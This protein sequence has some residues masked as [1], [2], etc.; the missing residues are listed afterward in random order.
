MNKE[1]F[2]NPSAQDVPLDSSDMS[3]AT[4]V[5]QEAHMIRHL[6]RQIILED[7]EGFKAGTSEIDY[8]HKDPKQMP[9]EL[10]RIWSQEADHAF[11][12]SV[13]KVHWIAGASPSTYGVFERVD[14]FLKASGKDEI[15]T[16]GYIGNPTKSEWGEF[17]VIVKGRTTLAARSMNDIVSGYYR[18]MDPAEI[19]KYRKTSGIP[20]RAKSFSRGAAEN[21]ILSAN[22]FGNDQLGNELIVDNWKATGLIAPVWFLNTMK[23]SVL[24]FKKR[25][26]SVDFWKVMDLF[27]KTELP[28][29]TTSGKPF[30]M[31]P[32]KK[33]LETE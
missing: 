20:R 5:V 7:M 21:F 1:I 19:E 24:D 12:D 23:K 22:D 26:L 32:I 16:M 30:N 14:G 33:M 8:G 27:I 3:V 28:I 18:E 9:R 6:I 10:K 31:T 17:G 29:Y 13:I 25:R 11:F 15:S 4:Q 2:T